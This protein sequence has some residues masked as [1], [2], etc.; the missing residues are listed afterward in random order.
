LTGY[1]NFEDPY[2]YKGGFVLLNKRGIRS[3]IE[4]EEFEVAMFALRALQALPLGHFDPVHYCSVHHHLFQDVYDWA[5]EYRTIRIAKND[6]MFCYPE[7]ISAQMDGLFKQ[8]NGAPFTPSSNPKDFVSAAASFLSDLNAIHPFREG[9]GRTQL[10]FLFMLGHRAAH[11]LDMTRIR[12]QEM[13]AAMMASFNGQLS[14]L[15]TEI[16]SLL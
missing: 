10:T 9:N 16:R 3:A 6:S 2:C 7:Y 13:L 15:E 4:L 8:L 11:P 12:P 5:G 1:G 14:G